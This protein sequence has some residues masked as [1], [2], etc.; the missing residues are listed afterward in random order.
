MQEGEECGQ[1]SCSG[2]QIVN[3]RFDTGDDCI[4]L[5][6]GRDRDGRRLNRPYEYVL[7]ENNEFADGHGGVA[8]GSEMSGGIRCVLAWKNLFTSPNLTY[9]LRLKTNAKRGGRAG[10]RGFAGDLCYMQFCQAQG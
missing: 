2:V 5:K 1:E 9:A 7:I 10:A 3:C 4:S 6:S 8:L